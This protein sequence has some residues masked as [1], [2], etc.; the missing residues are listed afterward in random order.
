MKSTELVH[1]DY[2]KWRRL[3]LGM[4]REQAR[5]L[6]GPPLST[7]GPHWVYG[8]IALPRARFQRAFRFMLWFDSCDRLAVIEHPFGKQSPRE[9]RPS[10]VVVHTPLPNSIFSHYP[11]Y[12]DI[13][14]SPSTGSYPMAYELQLQHEYRER[15][16]D[17]EI[18]RD[19]RLL[20]HVLL[21]P[22][23]QRGR[24]RVRAI[25]SKGKGPWS[26]FSMFTFTG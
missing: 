5:E 1:P 13:R 22:G 4:S 3:R 6:L 18:V 11:R 17:T 21:F 8:Y 10:R 20:H 15:F 25:N 19:L 26:P 12:L 9:G 24:L 2:Q 16:L 23:A 14:W 7:D